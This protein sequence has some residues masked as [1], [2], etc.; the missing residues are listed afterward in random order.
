MP[1]KNNSFELRCSKCASLNSV[2]YGL[3]ELERLNY[4]CLMCRPI[5]KEAAMKVVSDLN[6][7]IRIQESD[8]YRKGYVGH[9]RKHY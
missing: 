3:R 6:V 1:R 7:A 2:W 5:T 9:K 4:V 8:W